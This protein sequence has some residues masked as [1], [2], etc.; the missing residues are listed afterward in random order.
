MKQY[1]IVF[2]ITMFF[3]G[4]NSSDQKKPKLITDVLQD[5]KNV[6]Q[7][8][9]EKIKADKEVK[10]A[11]IKKEEHTQVAT[12]QKAET[13]EKTK[14]QELNREKEIQLKKEQHK[15]DTAFKEKVF[16]FGIIASALLIALF[17]YLF[18]RSKEIKLQIEREKIKSEQ[19][20]NE[21]N[22]KKD[23]V[24]ALI[25]KIDPKDKKSYQKLISMISEEKIEPKKLT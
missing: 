25:Q 8:E 16:I 23:M 14:M 7:I 10:I 9:L 22:M 19:N 12:I 20:I 2:L 6:T 24:I 5:Y 15:E 13:I 3:L 17:L 1:F 18:H 4:C 21:Q 11:T